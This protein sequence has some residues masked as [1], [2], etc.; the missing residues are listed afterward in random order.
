MTGSSD[1]GDSDVRPPFSRHRYYYLVLKIGVLSLA[2]V[3]ALRLLG[4]WS[5]IR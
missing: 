5:D 4:V 3:L 2:A 1:P